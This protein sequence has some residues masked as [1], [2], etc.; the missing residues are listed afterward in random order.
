MSR[1]AFIIRLAPSRKTRVNEMYKGNQIVIGWSKTQDKL[2][3][4]E[5]DREGFK[6]ILKQT[7][8]EMYSDNPYSVGQAAGYL[9]RFIR[10][11]Q[12]GDYAI[13]P[14][15]KAFYIGEITSD[16]IFM[17]DKI[18]DDTA[19]RRNVKWL[20]K[21]EPIPRNLCGSGLVSRLKYQGTCV[22]AT[23]LIDDIEQALK[24]YKKGISPSYKNQ[25]NE[26]LK[27]S[28]I[29]WLNSDSSLLDDKKFEELIR[30]LIKG[31][32]AQSS[33]IPPK[34]KYKG[35]IADVD[36]IAD[37][38]HLGIQLYIQ[39][40]KHK[41]QSDAHAVK[42]LIEALKIDNPDGT[43]PIYGWVLTSGE[44]APEAVKLADSNAIRVVNG[45]D[46]AEMMI[47]VGLQSFDDN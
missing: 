47:S 6:D 15:S 28:T 17:D 8:P 26:E 30:Q 25:L 11:M 38:V 46:L 13:V 34:S 32:G 42:Q 5:L 21:G 2:F 22:G 12:I 18:K 39:V 43:K 9:W 16:L 36:V 37:F 7:Y 35:S 44:F 20:N 19:I 3:N 10:E 27:K 33:Q 14:I 4:L 45:E 1:Q 40:K 24:S 41:K 29:K 23:D 31:L